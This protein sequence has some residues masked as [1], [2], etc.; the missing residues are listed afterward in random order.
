MN[1]MDTMNTMNTM[2]EEFSSN[3]SSARDTRFDEVVGH[4]EDIVVSDAFQQAND[5]F[6]DK[7]YTDFDDSEENK[8]IYTPIFNEYI[9][10]VEKLIERELHKR[11]PTFD[12]VSF[13]GELPSRKEEISEELYDMLLSFTDFLMFKELMLDHK[14]FRE[15]RVADLSFGLTVTPLSS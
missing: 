15:G 5:H 6:L 2:E 14:A 12:M 4:I 7:Y 10:T 1:T 8:L 9:S 3:K 13:M 11:M